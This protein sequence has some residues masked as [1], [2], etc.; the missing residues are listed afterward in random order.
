MLHSKLASA[1]VQK[2]RLKSRRPFVPA[3]LELLRV[4][5]ELGIS[6]ASWTDR[7]W[8]TEWQTS[9]SRLHDFVPEAGVRPPGFSLPRA[10]WVDWKCLCT[11]VRCF[12]LFL[13]KWCVT[14]SSACECGVE[15]Q[16]M[17]SWIVQFMDHLAGCVVLQA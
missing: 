17:S 15:E 8:Q 1:P 10:S 2:A 5:D 4:G 7:T 9:T 14:P 16:T 11:G 3:A 13:H 6:A 12:R